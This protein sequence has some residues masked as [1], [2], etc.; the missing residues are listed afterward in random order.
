MLSLTYS[1]RTAQDLYD[2]LKRDADSLDVV[3]SGDCVF[4]FVVT[5]YH[6]RE[7]IAK[8]RTVDP[9]IKIRLDQASTHRWLLICAD[10]ANASKH[11]VQAP[12]KRVHK[13]ESRS[14]YGV[15]RYGKGEYSVGEES[16]QL[17]L[18]DGTTVSAGE[19]RWGVMLLYAFVFG[20][21][22]SLPD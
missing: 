15:G 11:F 19:L 12:K 8:D 18:P 16:I 4:N 1:L 5:G 9:D 3:M 17:T 10:L 14:G 21:H 6:L 13:A 7:W 22:P 2:K 20:E